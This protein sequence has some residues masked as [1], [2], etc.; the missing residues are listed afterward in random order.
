M[1]DGKSGE[2]RAT[3]RERK[4]REVERTVRDGTE[5]GRAGKLCEKRATQQNVTV[6]KNAR[7]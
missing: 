7:Q 2:Q 3:Q 1:T 4:R 6:G 5:T